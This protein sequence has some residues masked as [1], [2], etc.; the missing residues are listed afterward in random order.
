MYSNNIVNFQ[1]STTIL[2]A[3][4]KKSGNLLKASRIYV[5]AC[6]C[7]CVSLQVI[8]NGILTTPFCPICWGCR[9]HWLHLCRGT[10]PSNIECSGYDTKQSDGEAPV[11][12]GSRGIRNISSLPLLPG[13]FWPG[14]VAPDRALS[15]C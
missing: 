11:M 1:E 8:T 5:C 15:M 14:V 7:V 10:K 4:T 6:V 13:P 3:C 9:I 12:L 2:N